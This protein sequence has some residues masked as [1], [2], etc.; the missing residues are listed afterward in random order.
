[1]SETRSAC[2]RG[3]A[4]SSSI[5]GIAKFGTV[6]SLG[7]AT[8][9]VFDIPTAQ[10]LLGKEGQFDNISVAAKTGVSPAALRDED[11]TIL[12]ASAQVRTGAE[13]AQA[14][15][16]ETKTFMKF[17][18]LFLLAF[19][20]I[21]LFVG[22]FVIFNTLSITVAQRTR[23]FAT[24]RALG[25][26]RRQVLRSVL[27]EGL[28]I[29]FIASI[30]GLLL[31]VGLAKGLTWLLGRL[32]LDLPQ[33]GT[34]FETR[35]V[36]VSM[37][38]GVGITLIATVGPALRATR[39]PPIAAVREGSTLPPSRFAPIAPI[40][41]GR[42]D[43][44]RRGSV[45]DVAGRRGAPDALGAAADRTRMHLR[46]PRRRADLVSSR[47]TARKGRRPAGTTRWR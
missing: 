23:E 47:P 41:G 34:V 1:M 10:R 7:G 33:T 31:G 29:G 43:R 37:L 9:A 38:V 18:Q 39:V 36:V 27:L 2:P 25:A 12:P 8:L 21:A 30:V 15:A 3:D 6:D 5:P 14:S 20:G 46:L 32:D 24:L 35:T 16:K 13:Q 22:A 40:R 19:G 45:R 26:S 44:G 42:P 4:W 17:I 28:V 11:P